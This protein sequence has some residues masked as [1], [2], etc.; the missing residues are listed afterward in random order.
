MVIF[1]RC[2]ANTCIFMAWLC[3]SLGAQA[4]VTLEITKNSRLVNQTQLET[5][6]YILPTGSMRKVNG[7]VKAEYNLELSG[8]LTRY[9]W[10]MIPGLSAK[11]SHHKALKELQLAD[12]QV[13][14]QCQGRSCGSS[15]KWANEV[16]GESRLYGLDKQQS[17]A[18]LKQKTATGSNY[19]ALY[20]TERG[21]KK[22]Y[23]HLEMIQE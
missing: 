9:T 20:S 7:V 8:Q 19:F 1:S 6:Y 3:V 11:T 15:H 2:M 23:L 21:N 4:G 17:Y 12:A 10:D 18:A 13:I 22:V 5:P 14:F 16:F